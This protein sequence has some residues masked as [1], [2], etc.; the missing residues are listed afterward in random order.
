MDPCRWGPPPQNLLIR[1]SLVF[2]LWQFTGC[3]LMSFEVSLITW[4]SNPGNRQQEQD[5][6]KWATVEP[7]A[8]WGQVFFYFVLTLP[9]EW[10][11]SQNS[12]RKPH[13]G[14]V[15]G[16]RMP[17][18]AIWVYRKRGGALISSATLVGLVVAGSG[19]LKLEGPIS[20]GG[21]C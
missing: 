10:L 13:S 1:L 18:S 9:L 16:E 12:W 19:C 15:C 5:S 3:H 20:G 6:Q 11:K 2:M 4:W 7:K 21:S 17:V 8:N 14:L